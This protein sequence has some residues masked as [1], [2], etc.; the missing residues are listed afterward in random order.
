MERL[1]STIG[2]WAGL[3]AYLDLP[4]IQCSAGTALCFSSGDRSGS[5]ERRIDL[6]AR[7]SRQVKGFTWLERLI[8]LTLLPVEVENSISPIVPTDARN[9]PGRV[10]EIAGIVF[11]SDS[12]SVLGAWII[13]PIEMLDRRLA[14]LGKSLRALPL[15]MHAGIHVRID[16]GREFVAEQLFGTPREDFVDGLNW[17]TLE[18]FRARDHHGWDVTVP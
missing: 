6:W 5:G 9:R 18:Q 8:F 14:G 15:A 1:S 3:R 2:P 13:R 10:R 16:D 7:D 4:P 17:T 11:Q 12:D